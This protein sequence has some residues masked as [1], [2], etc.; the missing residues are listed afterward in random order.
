MGTQIAL[1]WPPPQR[2]RRRHLPRGAKHNPSLEGVVV[3]AVLSPSP[4]ARQT[5]LLPM[6]TSTWVRDHHLDFLMPLFA[7]SLILILVMMSL[8]RGGLFPTRASR[9]WQVRLMCV[10]LLPLMNHTIVLRALLIRQTPVKPR[11]YVQWPP[12]L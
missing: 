2:Q 11:T 4:R 6:G 8:T 1:T 5:T 12:G 3:H 9:T 7:C 10:M